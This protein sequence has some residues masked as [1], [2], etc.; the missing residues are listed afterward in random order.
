M[1]INRAPYV[2]TYGTTP[3]IVK[4]VVKKRATLL[5][6]AVINKQ[7]GVDIESALWNAPQSPQAIAELGEK[8]TNWL[9][10]LVSAWIFHFH[11]DHYRPIL[12]ISKFLNGFFLRPI[13]I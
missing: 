12:I 10:I 1:R 13:L 6:T 8:D 5:S 11:Q 4:S 7:K 9:E 2:R 3:Q